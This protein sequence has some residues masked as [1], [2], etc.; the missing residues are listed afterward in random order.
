[1]PNEEVGLIE[2]IRRLVSDHYQNDSSPMLLANLGLRL[3]KDNLWSPDMAK[4]MTL[5]EFIEAAHDPDLV[6][7][8]DAN[9]PSQAG[10]RNVD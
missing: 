8:R 4:G 9:S 10:S 3:R 2:S 1:M 5:R 7:V 6:I